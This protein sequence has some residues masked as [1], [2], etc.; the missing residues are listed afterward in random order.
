LGQSSETTKDHQIALGRQLAESLGRRTTAVQDPAVRAYVKQ[1]GDR[2]APHFPGDWPYQFEPI[3]ESL[4]GSLHEPKALPGGIIFVSQNLIVAANTESEFA[5]ILAHAMAHVADD[6]WEQD[7]QS[8]AAIE[9]PFATPLAMFPLQ[10]ELEQRADLA[11]V[12][13][14]AAAGYDPAGLASYIERIRATSS[15]RVFV[16]V[17]ER[18][19]ASIRAGIGNLPPREYPPDSQEF[20]K[21]KADLKYQ[22]SQRE[23]VKPTLYRK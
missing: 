15:A 13:A 22:T 8:R 12:R 19:V 23:A 17:P 10:G 14:M 3:Q 9:N 18:R 21:T 1:V 11:A 7:A 20:L 2:L 5:G 4:L 6:K 16:E